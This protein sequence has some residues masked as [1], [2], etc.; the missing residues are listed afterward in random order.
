[1]LSRHQKRRKLIVSSPGPPSYSMPSACSIEKLG[2]PGDKAR[3]LKDL[4]F[5]NSATNYAFLFAM[6]TP[7]M[8][9][10]CHSTA[11]AQYHYSG[12]LSKEK[13]FANFADLCSAM[14]IFSANFFGVWCITRN[15]VTCSRHF[16]HMCTQG[17]RQ[18]PCSRTKPNGPLSIVVPSSSTV[19][20]G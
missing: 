9:C 1:M 19:K 7:S 8:A 12:K 20:S 6:P 17:I 4:F 3:K 5:L 16:R 10:A 11:Q 15:S 14:K 18:C 2:G 13:S